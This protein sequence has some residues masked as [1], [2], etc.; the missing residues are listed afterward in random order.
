MK[1]YVLYDALFDNP[2][3]WWKIL[4]FKNFYDKKYNSIG[5]ISTRNSFFQK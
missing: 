2:L 4:K 1:S 5:V 3:H